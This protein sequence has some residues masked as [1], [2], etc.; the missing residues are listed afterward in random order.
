MMLKVK[1]STGKSKILQLVNAR[2]SSEMGNAMENCNKIV[3]QL[4]VEWKTTDE[5]TGS[6]SPGGNLDVVTPSTD[7][8]AD[9]LAPHPP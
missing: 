5:G 4:F 1:E 9:P 6:A 7:V 3:D 8:K 2:N